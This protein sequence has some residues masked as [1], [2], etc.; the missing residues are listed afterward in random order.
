MC[1]ST[2]CTNVIALFQRVNEFY[3]YCHCAAH[4]SWHFAIVCYLDGFCCRFF[5]FFF[6]VFCCLAADLKFCEYIKNALCSIKTHTGTMYSFKCVCIGRA[7]LFHEE[8]CVCFCCNSPALSRLF[9]FTYVYVFSI[10]Y[11]V[12]PLDPGYARI[13][14]YI[15]L[16]VDVRALQQVVWIQRC[17]QPEWDNGCICW[18]RAEGRKLSRKMFYIYVK[19]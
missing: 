12:I 4:A 18:R 19:L 6:F 1:V 16:Q 7:L 10:T 5:F 13:R 2:L 3:A 14:L 15:A 8:L 11:I 17:A 9:V